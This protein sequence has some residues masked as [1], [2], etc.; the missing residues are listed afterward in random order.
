MNDDELLT[1]LH[2]GGK[3]GIT[4]FYRQYE[5]VVY[6]YIRSRGVPESARADLT[7]EIFFKLLR[8]LYDKKFQ[9]RC[10]LSSWLYR[11]MQSEI[12]IY[13]RKQSQ[14]HFVSLSDCS[15]STDSE[16]E[17]SN[18]F[19]NEL[20]E[21]LSEQTANDLEL[22]I[23]IERFFTKLEQSDAY[24]G[25]CLK[26]LWLHAQGEPLKNIAILINRTEDA[27]RKYVSECGKKLR[28]YPPLRDCW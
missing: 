2:R 27:T 16:A 26:I 12:Y 20:S 21:K 1:D 23:C 4:A 11:I 13:W 7:Q 5:P 25:N 19:C 9:Q 28:R 6:G 24:L 17:V 10:S 18:K 22:Q 3:E 14:N 15:E 8:S